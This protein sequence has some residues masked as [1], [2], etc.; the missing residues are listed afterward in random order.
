MKKGIVLP[1]L[2][3]A[4]MLFVGLP[5]KSAFAGVCGQNKPVRLGPVPVD[6]SVAGVRFNYVN[7]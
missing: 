2:T 5:M 4:L 3:I 7:T 6:N 1:A